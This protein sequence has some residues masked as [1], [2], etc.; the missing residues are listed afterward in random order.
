MRLW[1]WGDAF[2]IGPRGPSSAAFTAIYAIGG[3]ALEA[4]IA[5]HPDALARDDVDHDHYN[6]LGGEA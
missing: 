2:L 6:E 5:W 3:D 1:Y 4:G